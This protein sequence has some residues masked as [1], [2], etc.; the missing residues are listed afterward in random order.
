M[1]SD[2]LSEKIDIKKMPL[3]LLK[4]TLYRIP[5]IYVYT[6]MYKF[7]L[8]YNLKFLKLK[9]LHLLTAV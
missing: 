3:Q 9:S 5:G 7:M 1:T 6:Y 8:V 4:M 2:M